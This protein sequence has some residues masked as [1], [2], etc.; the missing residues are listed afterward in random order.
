VSGA[1]SAGGRSLRKLQQRSSHAYLSK[2]VSRSPAPPL[3]SRQAHLD[4]IIVP[5]SRPA[6]A[7]QPAIE[8]AAFLGAFLVVLCSRQ[9]K[10]EQVARRVARTPAAR[11][12]LV[13]I[14]E[15]W[16]H[17]GFPV[18]TSATE[19]QWASA[20]RT[21]DLSAKR[22]IGLLLA[23]LRGWNKI[24]F[25][26][27][28]VTLSQ[29]DNI[30]RLAGQLDEYQVAGMVVRR[31]PDNSVVN[32]ARRLAGLTQDV[33]VTGAVLGVHCNSLP[34][35]YFPDIYNEDWFFF[36]DEAAARK[37]PRVGNATQA[38]YDP[39][40]S[41]ARARGEEFGDLLA[42]GLYAL[43]G[44]DPNVPFDEQLRGAT[45]TYWNRFID[46]R[47]EAI[48]EAKT[49]LDHFTDQDAHNGYVT[50]ALESLTAAEDQL[51][52]ISTEVCLNFLE[53]WREDRSDWQRFLTCVNSVGS[54]REAMDFL[55]LKTWTL[56]EFGDV[57]LDSRVA[58]ID[59]ETT[60]GPAQD[61]SKRRIP[62]LSRRSNRPKAG[63]NW[64]SPVGSKPSAS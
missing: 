19:F 9:T 32:H 12:L 3:R 10:L 64:R 40:A 46:A 24:T 21:S 44:Q 31:F 16:T 29:T 47:H 5:A 54:I 59:G 55:L 56:A 28:D 25:V 13:Q 18:R 63:R 41:P 11:A 34:L 50:S 49:S 35:S 48:A 1:G 22:N 6:F 20:G 51:G 14:P 15:T 30:A 60:L 42:E 37:L 38:E 7:L 36:A 33:F 62:N 27:D 58:A 39:F 45:R 52:R 61:S 43:I 4:A 2:D 8:L 26:D 57:P 23:R 17:P 53:A